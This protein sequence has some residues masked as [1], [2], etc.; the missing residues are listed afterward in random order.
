MH[1]PE[2]RSEEKQQLRSLSVGDSWFTP[3]KK[4]CLRNGNDYQQEGPLVRAPFKSTELHIQAIIV[5]CY[6]R[7]KLPDKNHSAVGQRFLSASHRVSLLVRSS[8]PVSGQPDRPPKHRHRRRRSATIAT[9]AG[10]HRPARPA[11]HDCSA[12]LV[13]QQLDGLHGSPTGCRR[14][15]PR[16]GAKCQPQSHRQWPA[17][18][19]PNDPS[20]LKLRLPRGRATQLRALPSSMKRRSGQSPDRALSQRELATVRARGMR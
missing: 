9:A 2:R 7:H 14:R 8:S 10:P 4:R 1:G 15:R 6:K 11:E 19:N 5:A 18:D 12:H 16:P 13:L 17:I 20:L 3:R